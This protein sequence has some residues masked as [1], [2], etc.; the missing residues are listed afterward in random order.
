M[1]NMKTELWDGAYTEETY[2]DPDD[3]ADIIMESI[4][5]RKNVL[6]EAVVIKDNK[7]K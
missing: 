2:L 7:N 5:P 6:V 1:G 3:V 4:K